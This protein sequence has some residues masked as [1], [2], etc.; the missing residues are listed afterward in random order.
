MS[1]SPLAVVVATNPRG[2]IGRAG[3]LPWR[4]REDLSHF[5]RVTMGHA[6][7]MGRK[8]WDSIGRPLP[9]RRTI[10]VTRQPHLQ[11]DN[12]DVVQ[13]MEAAVDLARAGGDAEPRIVGG[14]S[15]YAWAMTR[16][17]RLFLTEVDRP[18]PDG[19]TFFPPWDRTLWTCVSRTPGRTEGVVFT[20]WQRP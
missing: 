4:I 11:I 20:E 16:A 2:V 1:R 14:A 5:K 17:T 12:V 18:V 3:D 13:S 8:T 9:G 19:D 6:M 15:V 7:V 10:V